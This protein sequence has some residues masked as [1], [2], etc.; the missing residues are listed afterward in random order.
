[1]RVF[2][3]LPM[4][5]TVVSQL[6]AVQQALTEVAEC[7]ATA[8]RLVPEHQFHITLAFLGEIAEAQLPAVIS[9]SEDV[10]RR[11]AAFQVSATR[12]VVLPSAQRP[13]VIGVA[14]DATDDSLLRAVALLHASLR[15]AG[16]A[17]EQRAFRA[18]VTLARLKAAGRMF[19]QPE[20]SEAQVAPFICA[21]VTVFQSEL[22]HAGAHYR[23]HRTFLL[24]R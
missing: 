1:M 22:S 20:L 16:F 3:A 18:H 12:L 23:E 10:A 15:Q 13:R 14:L 9:A 5:G 8:L 19:L 2:V 11:V 24:G 4:P 7:N 6:A 21:K 17:L